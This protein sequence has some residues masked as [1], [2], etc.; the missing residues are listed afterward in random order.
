MLK[1]HKRTKTVAESGIGGMTVHLADYCPELAYTTNK[2]VAA[3]SAMNA[4]FAID[5]VHHHLRK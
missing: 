3:N 5:G 1:V 4:V 2:E